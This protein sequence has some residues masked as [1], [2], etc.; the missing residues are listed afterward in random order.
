MP[1]ILVDCVVV[2]R[3]GD[4]PAD[5]RHGLQRGVRRRDPRAG[6]PGSSAWRS[7]S[8]RSSPGAAPSSCRSAAWST[9]ASA[10]PEGVAA[11]A[12]GGD[13][14]STHHPH[15]R[16]RRDRRHAAGRSRFRRGDQRR[17]AHRTRTSSSTSTTAVASTWPA[18]AWPS[19]TGGQRQRQPVRRAAR[20]LRAASSTSAR[21]PAPWCS[22]EP[23]RRA[24]WRSRSTT[25]RSGS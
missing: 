24:A 8:A 21:T 5:L 20:R 4:A 22:P 11:V 13:A 23:S 6:R 1:G 3:A 25:V 2:R 17:C 12:S 7:T 19:A 14:Y 18:S 15:R 16:A 10:C 9:W